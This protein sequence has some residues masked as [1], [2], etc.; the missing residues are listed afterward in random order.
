MTKNRGAMSKLAATNRMLIDSL[1][2]LDSTGN[3]LQPLHG[4]GGLD[5]N[6]GTPAIA[7]PE[8][9]FKNT[10]RKLSPIRRASPAGSSKTVDSFSEPGAEKYDEALSF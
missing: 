6:P 2:A 4:A 9:S 3:K 7:A 1:N 8:I 5:T 10:G